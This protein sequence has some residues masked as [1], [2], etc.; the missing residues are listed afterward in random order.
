MGKWL[1]VEWGFHED[2]WN[3]REEE[4]EEEGGGGGVSTVISLDRWPVSS[5]EY[6]NQKKISEN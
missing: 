1:V 4:Q 6:E 3:W 2:H 5:L